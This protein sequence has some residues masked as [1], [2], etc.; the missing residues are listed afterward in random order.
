PAI[1]SSKISS[2][3]SLP[4]WCRSRMREANCLGFSTCTP[5]IRGQPDFREVFWQIMRDELEKMVSAG[6]LGQKHLEPLLQ[7]TGSGYCYH[8]SWGFGKIT[9]V[10]TVFARFTIDFTDKPG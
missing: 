3:N 9:T 2:I 7:L 4:C 8:R 5:D 6:K 1:T 10:D